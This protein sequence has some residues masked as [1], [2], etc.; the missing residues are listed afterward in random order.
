MKGTFSIFKRPT[1]GLRHSL[2]GGTRNTL[3]TRR[4]LVR[5]QSHYLSQVIA[6]LSFACQYNM[7]LQG[8]CVNCNTMVNTI[9]ADATY[10]NPATSKKVFGQLQRIATNMQALYTRGT[11]DILG[12]FLGL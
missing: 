10:S 11:L 7:F 1:R 4:S 3:T 9:L 2:N 8:G 6:Y 12:H 5:V